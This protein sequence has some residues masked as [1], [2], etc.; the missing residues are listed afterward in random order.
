MRPRLSLRD[1]AIAACCRSLPDAS[2]STKVFV[3]GAG[4]CGECH[5]K[6][7]DEWEVV[8]AREGGELV[9]ST[10][11]RVAA[12]KDA[13]CDRCHAPLAAVAPRDVTV[14]RRRDVRRLPHAARSEAERDGGS[15]TLAIDD[16]V[17]Y[18]PR[19]DLK[20]HYF[21]RMGC[22]PEHQQAEL[23]GAC[24]WWEPKGIPVF[25]EYADWKAGRPAKATSRA[26]AA[27]CRR[28]GR[29]SRRARRC[30]PAFRIT[31]CSARAQDL[32]K[33]ALGLDVTA[34]MTPGALAI[35]V[36]VR[37]TNAG[38]PIPA[39]LPERRIVVRVGSLDAAGGARGGTASE[40][41]VAMLVDA[42]GRRGSVLA[43]DE[44]RLAT[45]AS[46]SVASWP[47]R[48]FMP[49]PRMPAPS[50]STSSIAGS[51]MRSRSSSR[52][53]RCEE[54]PMVSAK[55]RSAVRCRRLSASSRPQQA[56]ARELAR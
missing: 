23:C 56:N 7:F 2:R 50:R 25:T 29:R 44:G 12:A 16:M 55:I 48:R 47:D 31:A 30:G 27:T 35:A 43:R 49:A 53:P 52:S 40:R 6:M 34:A 17:K 14:E 15:F 11:R 13:T 51:P 1:G 28:S 33:R 3:T 42:S 5:E 4:R 21:H 24:H 32:R 19:C 54:H 36:T 8:G 26:R 37:N 9:D 10:R 18:G 22:S 20:D 41:S 38:H 45:R 46:P 39:G